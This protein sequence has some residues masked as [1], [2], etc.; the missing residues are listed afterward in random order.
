MKYASLSAVTASLALV[1]GL[2]V[3]AP[4]SAAD[5]APAGIV[6]AATA[7]T[8]RA[9]V[10][11]DGDG[12]K[13]RVAVKPVSANRF[14]V[15]VKTAKK[16]TASLTI[17]STITSDWG[18]TTPYWGA[19]K[20]DGVKGHELLLS[21]GGGDGVTTI[22]VTWRKG[23]LVRATAPQPRGTGADKYNWYTLD[24]GWGTSGYRVYIKKGKRYIQNYWTST[25]GLGNW[26]ANITTSKWTKSGWKKVSVKTKAVTAAQ[27]KKSYSGTFTGVRIDFAKS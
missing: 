5:H 13:D 18:L 16:R 21:I 1:G 4:A 10:D 9:K 19:A 12:R 25:D 27:V 11:V 8:V 3:A 7:K 22:A 14:K 6:K 26:T 17:T 24:T 15:I 23:K 20:I 2:L